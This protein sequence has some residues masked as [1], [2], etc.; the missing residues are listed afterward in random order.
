MK[1]S[2]SL[3]ALIVLTL[4]LPLSASA[5]SISAVH[6]INGTDLGASKAFPVDIAVDGNCA[7]TNFRF[8]DITGYIDLGRG[9]FD[10][11]ISVSDG[12]CGNEPVLSTTVKLK[13]GDFK[14]VVAQLD[15][16]GAP[17]TATYSDDQTTARS[18]NGRITFRHAAAAPSVDITLGQGFQ[19]AVITAS[20]LQNGEEEAL[21]LRKKKYNTYIA[22]YLSES[23]LVGP[24][25]L[26]A[27]PGMNTFIYAAG[28]LSNGTFE[29]LVDVKPLSGQ[30]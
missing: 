2:N 20:N 4:A 3:I 23:P 15:A 30:H 29:L 18:R 16:N 9:N 14:T 12:N 5:Q 13:N 28:S 6:A 19:N 17:I 11:D 1:L 7:L 8:G 27:S 21:T 25:P 10:I 26:S 22:A 24:I